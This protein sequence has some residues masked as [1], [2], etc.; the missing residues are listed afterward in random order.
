MELISYASDFVS[1]LI[2]NMKDLNQ[3]ESIILFGS[4][5]RGEAEKNSDVDIFIDVLNNEDKIAK[6]ANKIK[7]KFFDS[8]KFKK[9]W[10][11]IGINNDINLVVGKLDKWPLKDSMLGNSVILYQKYTPKLKEGKSMVILS[12][13]KIEPDS[14]RVML[15]KKLFGFKYR[16]KFYE[17]LIQKYKGRKLGSNVIIFPVEHL[18][19][20]L[21][22]IHYYK[23]P[24]KIIR[25]FEYES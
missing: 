8:V 13:E 17:G 6:E 4:T 23:V 14:R 16:K 15:N 22:S 24:A 10:E 18:N 3:I 5:A 21:K 25:V 2:Q 7:E 12:W 9:Y 1:F 11:L 20:F 19:F